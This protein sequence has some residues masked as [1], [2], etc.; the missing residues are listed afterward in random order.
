MNGRLRLLVIS[1]AVW[2][3]AAG[4]GG[5]ATYYMATGGSDENPGT[6]EAPWATLTYAGIH[7]KAGDTLLIRAGEYNQ[8]AYW[9]TTTGEPGRPITFAAYPGERVVFR[10]TTTYA[11]WKRAAGDIYSH[12]HV[13]NL[14]GESP[15]AIDG[16][17]GAPLE[18]AGSVEAMQPGSCHW[19]AQQKVIYVRLTGGR[20]P[21]KADVGVARFEYF[22][23]D[24]CRA[25]Y[26]A[27]RDLTFEGYHRAALA[28]ERDAPLTT[29]RGW[30][31]SNC[32]FRRNSFSRNVSQAAVDAA[33]EGWHV[34]GCRFEGNF[35]GAISIA[36]NNAVVANCRIEGNGRFDRDGSAAG[37]LFRSQKP[38][39]LR[40]HSNLV[41]GNVIR[42]NGRAG[43][44]RAGGIAIVQYGAS[45]NLIEGNLISDNEGTQAQVLQA[46]GA[47]NMFVNNLVYRTDPAQGAAVAY[48]I[49]D[50]D[51]PHIFK[52]VDW[53]V[54]NNTFANFRQALVVA[55]PEAKGGLFE[56]NLVYEVGADGSPIIESVPS[57]TLRSNL[58]YNTDGRYVYRYQGADKVGIE[59][60]KQAGA[61]AG[62]VEGKAPLFEAGK[63]L[64]YLLQTGSPA[65]NA[66]EPKWAAVR[67]YR[68]APRDARPD[69]GAF[70][71]GVTVP[72]SPP[73]APESM[74]L[75]GLP[76]KACPEITAASYAQFLLQSLPQ[77]RD[78]LQAAAAKLPPIV[79]HPRLL[80]T[81]QDLPRLRRQAQTTHREI[82]G[83][84]R[85]FAD[86]YLNRQPKR[87]PPGD[88]DEVRYAGDILPVLAFAYLIS[89][90]PRYLAT[91]K[92]HLLDLAE[93]PTWGDPELSGLSD[94]RSSH[95]QM[96]AAI[97]YDWLYRDLSPAERA[98][99]AAKLGESALNCYLASS[100]P[101]LEPGLGNWW[102]K[103]LCQNHHWHLNS[104]L[105]VAAL[106][107]EGEDPRAG[108][109]LG[110]AVEQMA[111]VKAVW[112]GS[113]TGPG[114]RG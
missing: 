98:R 62:C 54:V 59:G 23:T 80:L 105:G 25:H 78:Q 35:R 53:K 107:L 102:Q 16:A 99:V 71:Q 104:S 52:A 86:R 48:R 6:K 10:G 17:T 26:L 36:D 97:A 22:I 7:L 1:A 85:A 12:A 89:D 40:G 21:G 70:E 110:Q 30:E 33:L 57:L 3:C 49:V 92:R 29:N 95:L 27:F 56:N 44:T 113:G 87:P 9:R 42:S 37:I 111:R 114:T 93:W 51:W 94:L 90:D 60:L 77:V 31:I 75:S 4:M 65:V 91:A 20:D 34:E 38:N 47:G 73:A 69:I 18:E 79:E 108:L 13:S 50:D 63:E 66:G 8:Y 67:D 39:G 61:G 19:D 88:L 41:R 5:A 28:G 101:G 58:F 109:W 100:Y 64:G 112:R 103:T 72:A 106:A 76:W 96:G 45:G 24:H 81:A 83:P 74:G 84:I 46:T 82:W 2:V 15:I 68:G 55:I 32:T 11:D 14:W 43:V